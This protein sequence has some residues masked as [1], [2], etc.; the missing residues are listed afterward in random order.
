MKM[1]FQS[2]KELKRGGCERVTFSGGGQ[3]RGARLRVAQEHLLVQASQG[4]VGGVGVLLD[5]D[6]SG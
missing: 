1:S 2:E 4:V 5:E 3:R 6:V